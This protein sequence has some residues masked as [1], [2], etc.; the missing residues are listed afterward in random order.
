MGNKQKRNKLIGTIQARLP[1]LLSVV[2]F[3]AV[4]ALCVY[5]I[6]LTV[7]PMAKYD[8]SPGSVPERWRF[9]SAEGTVLTPEDGRL[10]LEE[11]NAVVVCETVI[12]EEISE[13]PLLVINAVSS[14]CVFFLN[15]QLVYSPS[16]RYADGRFS[17]AAYVRSGASG[18][19]VVH[20][21]EENERLTMIVQFQ[22]AENRL[23]RLPKLTWYPQVIY[24]LSQYT[25]PVAADALPAG[26]YLAIA[27]IV[28]GLFFIGS[29]KQQK[30]IGLILLAICSLSTAITYTASFSLSIAVILQS[31]TVTWFCDT[32]SLAAMGWMLWY[33][34]RSRGR[35]F[36]LPFPALGTGAMLFFLIAG[37]NNLSWV[38]Q[39]NVLASWILPAFL[40]LML[41]AAAWDAI[42][43]NLWYRRFFRCGAWAIPVVG[44][45]WLF[46]FL[47]GGEFHLSVN[48]AFS[49][50][51]DADHNCFSLSSQLCKLLLILFFFQAVLE[52]IQSLA[53]QDGE[54]HA[55]TMRE[56]YA[57]RNMEIMRQSQEE[58]R[59]QRHELN[60]HML[61]LEEMLAHNQV[62]QAADYIRSLRER[63]SSL[64]SGAYSENLVINAVAGQYLN[65][66]KAEGIKV[67]VDIKTGKSIPMKDEDLCVLLTNILE[68][69]L[70]ACRAMEDKS[71]RFIFLRIS[72]SEEHMALTCENST[73]TSI[74]VTENDVIPSSKPDASNHGYGIPAIRRIVDKYYGILKLS[75]QNGSF[76]VK[77]SL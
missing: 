47:T 73:D 69:A 4:L 56:E 43:G 50:I 53:R 45:M 11:E 27:L 17:S 16:G 5:Y 76:L 18:Q 44:G 61:A 67:D 41:I 52:M 25:G 49:R 12:T 59:S 77:V 3:A 40:L 1:F 39:M 51:L 60:H 26:I 20:P 54:L 30:D 2:L 70:E 31:P 65:T 28:M 72:A 7:A 38:K 19:F 22:G 48:R 32:L 6:R 10:S 9:S 8:L 21:S 35:L 14:D 37:A 15:G 66:A 36:T 13:A 57:I 23:S 58:T 34:L 63:V 75:R 74:P 55:L 42:R 33:R 46:S 62:E 24:Y 64:P 68:N 71:S 29:W